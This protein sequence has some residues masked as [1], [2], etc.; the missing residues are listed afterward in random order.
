FDPSTYTMQRLTLG[1]TNDNSV[2][3]NF[4]GS[5]ALTRQYSIHSRYG[6]F[7]IGFKV[8]DAHKT[9]SINDQVFKP[10]S[11]LRLTQFLRGYQNNDFYFGDYQTGPTASFDKMTAFFRANP[12][13]FTLNSSASHQRSDPNNYDTTERVYAGYAMNTIE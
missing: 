10:N 4:Q 1:G 7:E 6:A 2:Q 5:I 9:Q 13:A 11:D 12:S 8:R 3:L